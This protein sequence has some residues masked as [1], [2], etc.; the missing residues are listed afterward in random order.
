VRHSLS[1][2]I[3]MSEYWTTM[4][5]ARRGSV[6][7]VQEVQAPG[8]LS[9][10]LMNN[11]MH[12]TVTNPDCGTQNGIAM[13]ISEPDIVDRHVAHEFK[14]GHIH[15]NPGDMLTKDV[16]DM[17]RSSDKDAK[18]VVR[19]PLKCEEP[20]GLCQKCLGL[21][22]DG[23]HH[24]MG[25]NI[26]VISAQTVGERAVQLTLKSFHT[27]GV[28]ES[29]GGGKLLNS[30]ARFEQLTHL[31][32]KIP[33]SATLAMTGG[34][35]EKIEH[36]PTGVN[37]V[38]GGRRHFVGKDAAGN[39]YLHSLD[40]NS[41]WHG[42][43]EGMKIHAGEQLTDPARTYVNP[44]D[45]YRATGSIEKVQ[46][47]LTN[48]IF[49]LYKDEGIKRRHVETVVK[50]M[51]NL[52]KIH[53]PGDSDGILRGEF[54]PTSVIAKL[55]SELVKEGKR[56][57]EHKPVLK[58]INM[59]P[60]SLLEDWMAKLQHQRLKETLLE[61]AAI[62]ASSDLHGTHPVPGMAYGAEFGLTKEKSNIPGLGHL[63]DVPAHHY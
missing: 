25:T 59:M 4:H 58:G 5:G 30:F 15:L 50:A 44:H 20:K 24:P 42:I 39:S 11:T 51:S 17:V 57:I 8:Y 43:K 7:K 31:P 28:A 34:T 13:N 23:R 9:K 21:S 40:P 6:K 29:G 38:I 46:N 2:G 16:V 32:T 3:D 63:K 33:H 35:V 10:M 22:S 49:S 48:E 36:T 52:T 18:L 53:E 27:G 56:P 14:S 62:G 47:Q 61:S 54:H 12:V 37:V 55:N 19:S 26:G 60:L 41:S 45:L 1:E